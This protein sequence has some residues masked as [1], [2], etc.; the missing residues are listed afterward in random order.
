MPFYH[1]HSLKLGNSLDVDKVDLDVVCDLL[2][3]YEALER[4]AKSKISN[5]LQ[6]FTLDDYF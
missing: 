5:Y 2:L 1:A 3:R 4:E 6:D